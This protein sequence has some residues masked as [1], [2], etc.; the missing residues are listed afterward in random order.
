MDLFPKFIIETDDVLGDCLIIAKVTFHKDIAINKKNVKGGGLY[1]I[2]DKTITFY[3]S[4]VDFGPAKT[5]D[6]KSCI[7]AGNVFTNN[8]FK[9]SI[10]EDFK[11]K[12]DL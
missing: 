9:I 3:G 10:A 6:I 11:F 12:I 2:D 4:S 1:R 5:N 8:E 7:T